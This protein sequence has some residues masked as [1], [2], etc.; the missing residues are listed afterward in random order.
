VLRR[1]LA[2]TGHHVATASTI[3]AAV[4]AAESGIF[5]IIISDLVLPDG[6]GVELISKLRTIQP[7][8]RGIALS[9][10]GMEDDLRRS[11][12]AGFSAHLVKPV[13]YDQLRRTLRDM[14]E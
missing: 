7:G 6:T 14:A 11:K 5:D 8:L 12:E 9:S 4:T 10:Y 1:L 13:D 2:R 3:A